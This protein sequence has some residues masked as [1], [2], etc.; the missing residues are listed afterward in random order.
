[1][2]T[3]MPN[4]RVVHYRHGALVGVLG[5]GRHRTAPLSLGH[6]FERVDTRVQLFEVSPQEVPTSDGISV[7]VSAAARLQVVDP[8][9]H[10]EFATDPFALVYDA[11]KSWIRDV[12]RIHTL[13]Q[14]VA[15]VVVDQT[16]ATV[17]VAAASAGFAV[18]AFEIRDVLLPAEIKRAAEELLTAR[19][20]G[21][22]ALERA[23]SEVAVMRALANSA[24]ILEDH[25]ALAALRL[26]ETAASHGGTVVVER[27]S[28]ADR[29]AP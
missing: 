12:V 1:M 24:K 17:A 21:A 25:P 5:P 15:G 16:P 9:A 6:R 3:V 23:R 7:K 11:T 20:Q 29:S 26:A 10:L 18:E 22:V 14:L 2:V 28:G 4:E 27:P 19:Q 8:V 13:E